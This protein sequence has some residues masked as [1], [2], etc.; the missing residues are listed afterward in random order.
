MRDCF[1][2]PRN[3]SPGQR[4]WECL[5]M[6]MLADPVLGWKGGMGPVIKLNT[7]REM[8]EFGPGDQNVQRRAGKTIDLT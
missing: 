8:L 7:G 6:R 1:I 5:N 4:R 3:A 2:V